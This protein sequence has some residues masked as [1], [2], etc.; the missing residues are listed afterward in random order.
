[1]RI[2]GQVVTVYK[3]GIIWRDPDTAQDYL[4]GKTRDEAADA[5]LAWKDKRY[6]NRKS[7]DGLLIPPPSGAG[8]RLHK[9]Y[10]VAYYNASTR[11]RRSQRPMMTAEEFIAMAERAGGKCEVTG[12]PF[13][14]QKAPG[15]VKHMWAPSVDRIDCR[16]GYEASNCRLVCVAVNLALNEFG[17][18]V[19]SRIALALGSRPLPG[20]TTMTEDCPG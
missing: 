12:I 3:N 19:L 13:S 14:T 1:L 9:R 8:P 5:L 11:A 15:Q 2:F 18:D 10:Q 16:G 7:R 17:I 6:L 20:M 4:I